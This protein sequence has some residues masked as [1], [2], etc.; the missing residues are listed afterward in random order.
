MPSPAASAA[1]EDSYRPA[2]SSTAAATR[3]GCGPAQASPRGMR[4]NS[5]AR[6]VL[7]RGS[8]ISLIARASMTMLAASSQSPARVACCTAAVTITVPLIPP[9][10]PPVHSGHP[11]RA[12]A[13][14]LQPQHLREQR[15]VAIPP[16]PGRLDERVRARHRRQ[17]RAGLLVAGQF[18]GRFGI[19]MLQ[20]GRAQQHFPDLRRSGLEDL[21]HQV[22]SQGAVLGDQLLD[23]LVRVGM[24]V[25]GD[26][27]Q[28]KAGRPALGPPHEAFEGICRQRAAVLGQQQPGLGG[29]ESQVAGP[30]LGQLTEPA[31]SGAGAAADPPGRRPPGA[32]PAARS[33]GRSQ[34]RSVP[35][36][37]SG[38]GGR[39]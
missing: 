34:P 26:R 17:N 37:W 7:P 14:Q 9:G 29:T 3:Y 22:A 27:G 25:H 1:A 32:G 28:A 2:A 4:R 24:T 16:A 6:D 15:V 30:D 5:P 13:P 11:V 8:M 19:D 10:S 12:L 35:S 33:A 23:E 18:A 36:A 20:D 38:H 21:F 39:R 31:G